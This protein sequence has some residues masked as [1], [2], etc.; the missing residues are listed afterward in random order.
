L[1][2][3]PETCGLPTTYIEELA[4]SLLSED[5]R[6]EDRRQAMAS[7]K[8][9]VCTKK[10]DRGNYTVMEPNKPVIDYCSV[11]CHDIHMAWLKTARFFTL[12]DFYIYVTYKRD[13]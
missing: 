13:K 2:Y 12:F 5:S 11:T 3:V 9:Y 4:S 6:T 1:G 10:L 7:K 8:C